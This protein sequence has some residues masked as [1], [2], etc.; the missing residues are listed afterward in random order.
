MTWPVMTLSII[1]CVISVIL[2]L[3]VLLHKSK[4]GGLSDLFGGGVS[5]SMGGHSV[6]ERNLDRLTVVVGVLWLAC[7]V[8]LLAVYRY[9]A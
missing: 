2:T 7:I 1:L 3:F 9:G 6:A 4:G 5:T 8:A